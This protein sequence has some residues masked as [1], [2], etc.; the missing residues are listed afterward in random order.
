[1]W[2]TCGVVFF[3]QVHG[4]EDILKRIQTLKLSNLIQVI[5]FVPVTSFSHMS[6]KDATQVQP[7]ITQSVF[8]S[9]YCRLLKSGFFMWFHCFPV[10]N[11]LQIHYHKPYKMISNRSVNVKANHIQE[12]FHAYDALGHSTQCKTTK[13]LLAFMN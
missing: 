7:T 10:I 5:F 3:S 13:T 9:L 6:H 2:G 1:M 12:D 8:T 11:N 4:R